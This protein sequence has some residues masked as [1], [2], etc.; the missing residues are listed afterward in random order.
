MTPSLPTRVAGTLV[1]CWYTSIACESFF[2]YC[3]W[4]TEGHDT[5]ASPE[6]LC[7]EQPGPKLN[8]TWWLLS[9]LAGLR[10][11]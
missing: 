9:S 2:I 1:A 11:V 4:P 6:P 7:A 10:A 8:A 3:S 5:H